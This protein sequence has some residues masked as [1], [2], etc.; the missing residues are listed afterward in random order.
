MQSQAL[1]K[2]AEGEVWQIQQRQIDQNDINKKSRNEGKLAG[3]SA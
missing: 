3:T 2:Y 1:N